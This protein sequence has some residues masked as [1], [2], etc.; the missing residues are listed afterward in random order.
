MANSVET[1]GKKKDSPIFINPH[2]MGKLARNIN[3]EISVNQKYKDKHYSAKQLAKDLGTNTRYVSTVINRQFGMNYTSFVNKFRI[4]EAMR[5]LKDDRMS[6]LNIEEVSDAVGFSTRQSFYT[7][8]KR[9]VW[10]TPR[11]YRISQYDVVE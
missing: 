6:H 8:F 5:L 7:S 2:L 9:I 11:E 1:Q 10:M 3:Q 4:E